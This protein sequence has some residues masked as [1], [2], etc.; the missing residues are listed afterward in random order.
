M[1]ITILDKLVFWHW[2]VLALLLMGIEI[3]APAALFIWCGI[4]A[5]A[6][7]LILLVMPNISWQIQFVLFALLAIASVFSGRAFVHRRG[8][9]ESDQ[10]NLNRRGEQYIGRTFTLQ[11][12][13][14]N[15]IGRMRVDDSYWRIAGEDVAAG[16][17][18]KVTAVEGST[19]KVE[20]S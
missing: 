7:G 17:K 11:E 5:A 10:P 4:A 19:L 8:A 1:D 2:W 18:V 6:V 3:F 20:A 12:A 15:G 13:I 14:V 16:T 9:M